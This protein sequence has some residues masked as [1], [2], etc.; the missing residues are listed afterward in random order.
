M[1]DEVGYLPEHLWKSKKVLKRIGGPRTKSR[2]AYLALVNNRRLATPQL[3]RAAGTERIAAV[4]KTLHERGVV[5]LSS[6]KEKDGLEKTPEE[7]E[8]YPHHAVYYLAHVMDRNLV[9]RSKLSR[10]DLN[11]LREAAAGFEDKRQCA[12]CSKWFESSDLEADHRI[13]HASGGSELGG[14]L[15]N[16][17]LLCRSCNTSKQSYC[18]QCP[19]PKR[20]ESCLG[21]QL[22]HPEN[23]THIGGGPLARVSV[24][25]DPVVEE[26]LSPPPVGDNF[27]YSSGYPSL[28]E[29]RGQMLR[30]A[31]E[32]RK[33]ISVDL[34]Q[35]LDSKSA[36]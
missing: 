23:A 30:D 5:I 13:P 22:A 18:L 35:M 2:R 14:V 9:Q 36:G 34:I 32:A 28:Q 8:K 33:A 1:P 29:Q 21:C 24:P 7:K 11:I 15:H 27:Q 31:A 6:K 26:C 4:I 3:C 25:L 12:Q 19:L 20:V 10:D 16:F 17:Q